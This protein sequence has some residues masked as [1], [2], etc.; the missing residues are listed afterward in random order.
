MAF[1]PDQYLQSKQQEGS[2]NPDAYL[3]A[4][5]VNA[6][7]PAS[8]LESALRGAAQGLTFGHSDEITGAGEAL[9]DQLQGQ[10]DANKGLLDLYRQHRD[11]SRAA[12][13]NAEKSNPKTY[14]AGNVAGSIPSAMLLPEMG[15]VKAGAALG[16]LSGLGMGN[17]DLTKGELGKAALETGSGAAMG[18]VAGKVFDKLGNLISPE[19][20][21][22][23]AN[24]QAV[25]SLNPKKLDYKKMTPEQVQ[26]LGRTMLDNDVITP[27]SSLEDKLNSVQ[28]LKQSSG[29]T[30]GNVA[31][32]LDEAGIKTFNPLDVASRLHGEIAAPYVNEPALQGLEQQASGLVESA[33]KRGDNPISF[34]EA[35]KLKSVFDELGY[36]NGNAVSGKELAQRAYGVTRDELEKAVES[37]ANT[38]GDSDLSNKFLSAKSDYNKSLQAENILKDS[39]AREQANSTIGLGDKVVAAGQLAAGN[40]GKAIS[41]VGALKAASKYGN[42]IA[43]LS[44]DKAADVMRGVNKALISNPASLTN[45]GN[46]LAQSSSATEASL[47]RILQGAAERDDVGRNALVFSLMQNDKYRELLKNLV[48]NK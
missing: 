31:N 4:K 6:T 30:I 1:D 25:K 16:A 24:S 14:L 44:T 40:P 43:A 41:Q 46:K 2:F 35:N 32:S 48:V 7:A 39:F 34:E 21:E 27:L 19:S 38:L 18:A 11:E 45:I 9:L 13:E 33:L 29:E 28:A 23:A 20:L 10:G 17:A 15:A 12:Y 36:K 37:G 8:Q 42:N 26:T 47:G 5:G 22:S 3:S